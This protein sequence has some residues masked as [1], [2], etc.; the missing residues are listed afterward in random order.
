MEPLE[1]V[2]LIFG[3]VLATLIAALARRRRRTPAEV[4]W[5]GERRD[6]RFEYDDKSDG[7]EARPFERVL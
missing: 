7:T 3:T 5:Y 1:I 6:G 4:T 2:A